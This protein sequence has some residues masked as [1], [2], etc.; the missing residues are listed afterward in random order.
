VLAEIPLYRSIIPG[1]RNS[2]ASYVEL[3]LYNAPAAPDS[4]ANVCIVQVFGVLVFAI[5]TPKVALFVPVL[6]VISPS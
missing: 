2:I 1:V 4:D 3:Y 5:P 6:E